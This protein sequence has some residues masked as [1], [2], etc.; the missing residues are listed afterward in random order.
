[1]PHFYTERE[2]Q[3]QGSESFKSKSP[4][5]FSLRRLA[6]GVPGGPVVKNPLAD[7][8]VMGSITHQSE[9]MPHAAEQL[10]SCAPNHR[11]PRAPDPAI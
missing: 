11:S 2:A 5:T 4:K 7:A 6:K 1:M 10:N 9:Q 3:G 8:G